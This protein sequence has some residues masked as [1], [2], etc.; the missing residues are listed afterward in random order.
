MDCGV[1]GKPGGI[2]GLLALIRQHREAIQYDLLKD[3][4]RL[5]W[6][7]SRRLGWDD[8]AVWVKFL[9][10]SSQTVQAAHG[11]SW[12]PELHMLANIVDVLSWANWQRGGGKGSKPK[13][14]KRPGD[15]NSQTF[16][17]AV[18]IDD[19]RQFL[20]ERNGRAPGG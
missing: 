19:V 14:V 15:K 17:R 3:G 20:R 12:S 6:L 8:F 18:P 11:P 13:P 1:G 7:G 9:P 10:A 4:L 5:S 16:G 2:E